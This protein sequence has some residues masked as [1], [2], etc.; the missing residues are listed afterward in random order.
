MPTTIRPLAARV[1]ATSS[2]PTPIPRTTTSTRSVIARSLLGRTG[3]HG[4][5]E[6]LF[7]AHCLPLGQDQHRHVLLE[8]C[9]ARAAFL[10]TEQAPKAGTTAYLVDARRPP[11]PGRA[12]EIA[13]VAR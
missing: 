12:H 11:Q 13:I 2:P 3:L 5:G 9:P 6:G 1:L 8:P 4:I 10:F 7:E